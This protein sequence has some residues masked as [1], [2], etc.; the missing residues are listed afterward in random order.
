L[1]LILPCIRIYKSVWKAPEL[2]I[3]STLE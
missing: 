1:T 3:N 2:F